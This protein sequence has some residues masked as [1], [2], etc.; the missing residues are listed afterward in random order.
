MTCFGRRGR[1]LLRLLGCAVALA[2]AH[3]ARAEPEGS[4]ASVETP[5]PEAAPSAA[6]AASLPN[7]TTRPPYETVRSLHALQDQMVLGSAAA[8]AALPGLAARI[9][10]SLLA[11]DPE[12][13]RDAR[14]ARAA[15]SYILSGGQPRVVR[16]ILDGDKLAPADRKLLEGALSYVD[17]REAK[18]R[19]L[20]LDID[21]K[22]LPGTL[23]GHLALAQAVLVMRDNPARAMRF[24]DAARLLAPGTLVEEAALRRGIVLADEMNDY[25]RF[26]ALSSQYLRRFGNSVYAQS[27]RR[28]FGQAVIRLGLLSAPPQFEELDHLLGALKPD[29]RDRL[30]LAMA[31]AAL[32][33]GKTTTARMIIDRTIG[34]LQPHGVEG[35]QAVLYDGAAALLAGNYDV[36]LRKIDSVPETR[37]PQRDR[38]L[39]RAARDLAERIHGWPNDGGSRADGG[40]TQSPVQ[41]SAVTLIAGAEKTLASTDAL[42]KTPVL[43]P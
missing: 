21:A 20:L 33:A 24:L 15:V 9:A 17:G 18:A 35:D 4:S 5:A 16:K 23:G 39:Q 40:G 3:P 14:N 32:I 41:S 26:V 6:A 10:E 8:Q 12:A 1:R 38:E 31:Q 2:S 34:T 25:E 43:S 27:F 13:W 42:L 37:L 28:R 19:Q 7:V 11:A 30:H 22:R 29:E 36:G